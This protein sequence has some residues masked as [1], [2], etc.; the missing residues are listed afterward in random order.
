MQWV[1]ISIWL[2]HCGIILGFSWNKPAIGVPRVHL[3]NPQI[4]MNQ[5]N[6]GKCVSIFQTTLQ[7]FRLVNMQNTLLSLPPTALRESDIGW[8]RHVDLPWT[9]NHLHLISYHVNL[10]L[11]SIV[12]VERLGLPHNFFRIVCFE[13]KACGQNMWDQ[14]KN[15]FQWHHHKTI[16]TT[17]WWPLVVFLGWWTRLTVDISTINPRYVPHYII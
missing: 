10:N 8:F 9:R 11:P 4:N 15:D 2:C 5:S 6:L 1:Q 12:G 17:S 7:F 3:W 14:S 16:V 13:Q